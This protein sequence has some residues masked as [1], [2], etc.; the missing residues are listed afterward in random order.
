MGILKVAALW[1]L[2]T[3][4]AMGL[5]TI[6]QVNGGPGIMLGFIYGFMAGTASFAYGVRRGWIFNY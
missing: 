6:D 4:M 5:T 1:A 3:L 2:L